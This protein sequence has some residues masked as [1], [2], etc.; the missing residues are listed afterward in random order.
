MTIIARE[1]AVI[2]HDFFLPSRASET[3]KLTDGDR[4]GDRKSCC[5]TSKLLRSSGYPRISSSG[6]PAVDIQQR[7]SSSGY[8]AADIQQR[9]SAAGYPTAP[10]Q[11]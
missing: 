6:Y 7:I 2:T 9:I 5:G 3:A 4:R 11:F 8:P 10:E 1:M